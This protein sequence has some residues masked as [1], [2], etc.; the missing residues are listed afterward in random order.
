[1]TKDTTNRR[2]EDIVFMHEIPSGQR[3]AIKRISFAVA[4]APHPCQKGPHNPQNFKA[5]LCRL[6]PEFRLV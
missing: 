2:R 6:M 5:I 3:S 4:K 1:M